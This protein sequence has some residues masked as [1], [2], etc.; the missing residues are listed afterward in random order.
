VDNDPVTVVICPECERWESVSHER[1]T[2]E[3]ARA[4]LAAKGITD[5][6]G[7]P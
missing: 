3:F 1:P 2:I 6:E 5:P 4:F 7:Q